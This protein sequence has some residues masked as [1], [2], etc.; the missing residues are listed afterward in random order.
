MAETW[1]G[2]FYCVKCKEKRE[3]ERRG[4]GQRQGHPDGQGCLPRLRHE[5]EPHPRQGLI[6]TAL[7]AGGT[8]P[9]RGPAAALPGPGRTTRSGR[10]CGQAFAAADVLGQA[11]RMR[12][13]LRPGTHVLRRADGSLQLGLDPARA[14]V[15]RRPSRAAGRSPRRLRRQCRTGS[16]VSSTPRG[17][18]VDERGLMPLIGLAAVDDPRQ[19]D[20][21][22]HGGARPRGGAGRVRP[23]DDPVRVPGRRRRLRPPG[24]SRPRRPAGRP[25]AGAPACAGNGPAPRPPARD[26]GAGTAAS[27]C[28]SAWASRTA[29]W[30]TRGC[31]SRR[32]SWSSGSPRAGPSSDRSSSPA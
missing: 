14:V 7:R 22:R 4:Q 13:L 9:R 32:P 10:A 11:H 24:R 12:P 19:R 21:P 3:A 18:L 28:C 27:G 23:G 2:E 16:S 6:A 8:P 31:G 25:A 29:S 20:P 5:P 15:R 30:P 17:L 26:A 1:S